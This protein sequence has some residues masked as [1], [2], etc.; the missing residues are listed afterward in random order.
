MIASFSH[1]QACKSFNGLFHWMC[2][3]PLPIEEL[4]MSSGLHISLLD[5][6]RDYISNHACSGWN[7]QHYKSLRL[8]QH[9][10]SKLLSTGL[11]GR[12]RKRKLPSMEE[13]ISK[14][15]DFWRKNINH[16][17]MS[18]VQTLLLVVETT[19]G[20]TVEHH[21]GNPKRAVPR[22]QRFLSLMSMKVRYVCHVLFCLFSNRCTDNITTCQ[23][24]KWQSRW[25]GNLAVK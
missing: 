10:I 20:P 5:F 15:K 21:K 6:F 11:R 3:P 4:G 9:V 18:S 25:L 1:I 17:T 19:K 7:T 22:L 24:Q 8:F 23:E 14:S 13:P 2:T 12:P 16:G